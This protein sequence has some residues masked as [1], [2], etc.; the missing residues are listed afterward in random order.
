MPP[1]PFFS[2]GVDAG[3]RLVFLCLWL[4][5]SECLLPGHRCSFVFCAAACGLCRYFLLPKLCSAEF[6]H[7]IP[8]ALDSLRLILLQRRQLSMPRVGAFLKALISLA[9]STPMPHSSIAILA[10][11]RQLLMR[12]PKVRRLLESVD[13]GQQT[14]GGVVGL[15]LGPR[16][17]R[18]DVEPDH[19]NALEST[20]WEL[21]CLTKHWHPHVRDASQ[22]LLAENGGAGRSSVVLASAPGAGGVN[23]LWKTYD[24][25]KNF[26]FIPSFPPR[27]R[28]KI[29]P[30][31]QRDRAPLPALANMVDEPLSGDDQPPPCFKELRWAGRTSS[32]D[33]AEVEAMA[34]VLRGYRSFIA[35]TELMVSKT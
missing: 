6:D 9:A 18:P 10:F 5:E 31:W 8:T 17:Y 22:G 27:P 23:Q 32:R 33:A 24:V 25:T 34:G 28:G 19:A 4:M 29:A 21:S 7:L 2:V 14:T 1:P 16:G 20:A 15:G 35:R 26:G 30:S 13:E 12:Y 11:S 3:V